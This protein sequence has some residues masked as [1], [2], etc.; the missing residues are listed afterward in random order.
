MT[1]LKTQDRRAKGACPEMWHSVYYSKCDVP[2]PTKSTKFQRKLSARHSKT[3]PCTRWEGNPSSS[4][5]TT[6]VTFLY[7]VT[8]VRKKKDE[9]NCK[10]VGELS[11]DVS[12]CSSFSCFFFF[13]SIAG[14]WSHIRSREKR[15]AFAKA[16]TAEAFCCFPTSD[17]VVHRRRTQTATPAHKMASFGSSHRD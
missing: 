1:T 2:S 14:W 11:R 10:R 15:H 12:T 4:S 7:N 13:F 17:D 6:H 8:G 3:R 16:R 9:C 5:T